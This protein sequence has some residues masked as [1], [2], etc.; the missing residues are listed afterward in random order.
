[1]N[2]KYKLIKKTIVATILSGSLLLFPQVASASSIESNPLYDETFHSELEYLNNLDSITFQNVDLYNIISSKVKELNTNT[3]KDIKTLTIDKP[4]TNTD[5]S[6]LKYLPNLKFLIIKNNTLDLS[7]LLYNQELTSLQLDNCII[8]NS[9]S[10]PNSI[11]SLYLNNCY[12]TSGTLTTPYNLTSLFINYTPISKLALKNP[13]NLKN[14]S[15][16]GNSYLS[17]TDIEECYNLASLTIKYNPSI[18]DSYILSDLSLSSLILD[19]YASI[20]LDKDIL[21]TLPISNDIEKEIVTSINIIDNIYS[22]LNDSSLTDEEKVKKISLY[23]INNY[24]YNEHVANNEKENEEITTKLNISPISTLNEED[25]IICINYACLFQALANRMGLTSYEINSFNHAYNGLN[26]DNNLYYYDLTTLDTVD[27]NLLNEI[28][29]STKDIPYYHLVNEDLTES[30]YEGSILPIIDSPSFTDIGYYN[31]EELSFDDFIYNKYTFPIY[32]AY[33]N[34]D[35]GK[36]LLIRNCLF[37]LFIFY[38]LKKLLKADN[39]TKKLTSN[40]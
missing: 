27:N 24:Y 9:E 39:K 2:L 26:L 15:L 5:L 8:N 16:I 38:Y 34:S 4:L 22:S 20:W 19:E 23:I 21:D 14:L 32:S 13:S 18:K 30:I 31:E 29:T 37:I 28:F 36:L 10:L 25:G 35:K 40:F 11:S 33:I 12:I 1:M 3:I 6:D 7:N 17:L